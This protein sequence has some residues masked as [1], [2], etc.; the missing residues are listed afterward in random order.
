VII[1]TNE[2]VSG[3]GNALVDLAGVTDLPERERRSLSMPGAGHAA[4]VEPG[5]LDLYTA[6]FERDGGIVEERIVGEELL[7]PV[8]SYV[9]VPT[10]ASSC[11]PPMISYSVARVGRATRL[12]VPRRPGLLPTDQ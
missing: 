2:G 4:G 1:K 7:S 11:C 9:P 3:S 10:A 6:T 5:R 8:S 12:P